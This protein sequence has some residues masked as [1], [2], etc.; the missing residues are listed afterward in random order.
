MCYPVTPRDLAERTG[1]EPAMGI[2]HAPLAEE[3]FHQFSHLSIMGWVGFEPTK[4]ISI[5]FTDGILC[6]DLD[7][8]PD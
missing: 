8:N 5:R 6:P 1:F 7:T 2:N 3:C 4:L